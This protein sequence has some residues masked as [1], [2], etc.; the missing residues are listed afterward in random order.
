ME[1]EVIWELD[2]KVFQESIFVVKLMAFKHA[3]NSEFWQ[4]LISLVS[5][6]NSMVYRLQS[7]TKLKQY[8]LWAKNH[9]NRSLHQVPYKGIAV[10]V[11]FVTTENY[12]SSYVLDC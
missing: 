4:T 11:K 1:L 9:R 10:E 12:I 8:F 7:I 3:L 5:F 6:T 2:L